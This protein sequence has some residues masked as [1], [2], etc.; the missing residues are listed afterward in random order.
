[1][2]RYRILSA[3]LAVALLAPVALAQNQIENMPGYERYNWMRQNSRSLVS[4][5]TVDNVIWSEDGRALFFTRGEETMRVDLRSLEMRTATPDE[6]PT[7]ERPERGRRRSAGRARQLTDA[8]S[9]DGVWT[10]H[11]RDFNVVLVNNETEEE[12][13]VTT[14]GFERFRYGTACWV[15]GEELSQSDAMWWSPD[16][17][18]LAFYEIDERHCKVF[19][20]AES[21]I[22]TY[23]TLNTEKY[24]KAGED[25]PIAGILIYDM[26]DGTLTRV[27]VGGDPEQYVYGVSWSPDGS[28]LIYHRTNRH[29]SVLEMM[30]ADPSDG[31]VR[32]IVREEQATWQDNHPTMRFL[33]DG[34]HF[35]WETERNGWRNYELRHLDGRLINQLTAA[36]GYPC[37]GIAKVDE[38]AGLFFYSAR[39]TDHPYCDQLHRV[40]LNGRS[41]TRLTTRDMY[42]SGFNISPDN[43]FFVATFQAAEIPPATAL[44]NDKGEEVLLLAESDMTAFEEA[45]CVLPEVYT[46]TAET[47]ETLYGILHK[48]SHFDPNRSYPVIASIYGGPGSNGFSNRFGGVDALCEFGFITTS[49]DYRG[50]SGRGKEFLGLGYMKL[51]INEIK[52]H[53]D[54][55][56]WLAEN[57]PYVDGDRV[58]IYGHSYGGYMTALALC[59][60]PEVFHVGVSGAPVTDWKNYD[61]IYTERY[62]RTPQ[63]NPDGYHDGSCLTW[64]HQ[65]TGH[66]LI[67]HGL[68]DD[69]VHPQNSF[70]LVEEFHKNNIPFDIQIFPTSTHGIRYSSYYSNLRMEYFITHLNPE[71]ILP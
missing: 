24:P 21:L 61:T 2:R 15:Y 17:K 68:I 8:P 46:F 14:T 51:G 34:Q 69:N 52:D 42:Y 11:Y 67:V 22:E 47:G 9:P 31:N 7:V 1:M 50:A 23:P 64:A 4:G 41:D 3:L 44:Y 40:R 53:A 27:Q 43:S 49:I 55:I 36:D 59:K 10:A 65:L 18:K 48:P 12:V 60:Y 33:E 54:A 5:G 20:L 13:P 35:I 45:G 32:L 16:S 63:E 19:Y 39:S 28:E 57:K 25:N 56:T 37:S 71:P 66:L 29:Q 30:A 62:M 6:I 26:A 58:G 70:M 38:E